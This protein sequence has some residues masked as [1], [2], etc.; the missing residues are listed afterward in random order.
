M[1]KGQLIAKCGNSGRSPYPHLHF[2]F[3]AT[4]YIGSATI[5][6]PFGSYLIKGDSGYEMVSFENPQ[7]ENV[8]VNPTKNDILKKA[9]HFVPGQRIKANVEVESQTK[10]W[11]K[12]SGSHTWL[13]E[14][15]VYNTTSIRSEAGNSRAYLYNNGD[16]HFFTNFT[17]KRYSPLFWFFTSIY[18]VPIG[19]LPNSKISDTLP[20][21]L[22]FEGPIKFIQDFIAPMFLFLKAE[23]QLKVKESGDI[24]SSGDVEAEVLIAKKIFNKTVKECKFQIKISEEGKFEISVKLKNAK[25][26]IACQNES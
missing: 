12:L 19:F 14:T 5:D 4:P 16:L 18:K 15:D 8:V 22:L 7:N 21:N 25:I 23:Y 1:K 26:K 24:L 2:Q 11:Q 3:Q 6:Y 10:K 20:V 9:L 13:V 17:G